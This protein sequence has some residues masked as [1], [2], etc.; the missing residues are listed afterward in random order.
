VVLK[1]FK[2]EKRIL[3]MAAFAFLMDKPYKRANL[4]ERV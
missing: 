3:L 4:K 1:R 2:Y